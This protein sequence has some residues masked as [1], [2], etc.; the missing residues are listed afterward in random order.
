MRQYNTI[1]KGRREE[2]M[3]KISLNKTKRGKEKTW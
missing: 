1:Q 2:L 3:A